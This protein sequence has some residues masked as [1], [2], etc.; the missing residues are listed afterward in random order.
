MRFLK[1]VFGTEF[2]SIPDTDLAVQALT[3]PGAAPIR[4]SS[5][6]QYHHKAGKVALAGDAAHTMSSA[7]GQVVR[8]WNTRV[9]GHSAAS[10]A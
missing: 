9:R 7:L 2:G 3:G 10:R 8:C 6:S 1:H 5:I 4:V